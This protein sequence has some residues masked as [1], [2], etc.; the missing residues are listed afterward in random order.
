MDCGYRR[1]KHHILVL[2]SNH[3]FHPPQVVISTRTITES[4]GGQAT[5]PTGQLLLGMGDK[6]IEYHG[7]E[8]VAILFDCEM[9]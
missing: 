6:T 9:N 3:I 7:H 4:L 5:F 2:C 8:S 1:K